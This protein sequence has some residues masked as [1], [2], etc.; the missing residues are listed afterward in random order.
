MFSGIYVCGRGDFPKA[1]DHKRTHLGKSQAYER[2][3]K[4]TSVAAIS[5]NHINLNNILADLPYLTDWFRMK[6][7]SLPLAIRHLKKI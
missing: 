6:Y 5:C 3:F 7:L 4:K 1:S 2:T